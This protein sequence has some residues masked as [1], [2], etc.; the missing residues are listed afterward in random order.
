MASASKFSLIAQRIQ[1]GR[2]GLSFP[3]GTHRLQNTVLAFRRWKLRLASLQ[4]GAGTT[5]D[6]QMHYYG[7]LP[8]SRIR[9]ERL[10]HNCWYA[11][12]GFW[13]QTL[14]IPE[15]QGTPE[16]S[17][18]GTGKARRQKEPRG[19]RKGHSQSYEHRRIRLHG[20]TLSEVVWLAGLCS[21]SQIE[22][23]ALEFLHGETWCLVHHDRRLCSGK[24]G[25]SSRISNSGIAG[26]NDHRF[27]S[28]VGT[29]HGCL[30]SGCVMRSVE[31]LP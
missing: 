15:H 17:G 11:Q 9:L 25:R 23:S 30:G 6:A 10:V 22:T 4:A 16:G 31:T 27:T 14:R 8:A 5:T 20:S 29:G 12:Y 26:G 1:W 2:L 28:K 18:L 19:G 7:R 13:S 21:L 24:T 3:A